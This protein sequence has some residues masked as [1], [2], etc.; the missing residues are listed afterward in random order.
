MRNVGVPGLPDSNTRVL[1]ESIPRGLR[2][3]CALTPSS[4]LPGTTPYTMIACAGKPPATAGGLETTG[5]A[6]TEP[7]R[8]GGGHTGRPGGTGRPPDQL[9]SG[10]HGLLP[11]FVAANQRE[12]IL[13]AVAQATAELG[14]PQMSVE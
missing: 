11:S 3:P 13:S 5:V 2:E 10:R 12:R 4:P 8:A 6:V 1:G 14:Y 9:P 7:A